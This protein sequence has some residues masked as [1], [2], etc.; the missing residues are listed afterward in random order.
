MKPD[1]SPGFPVFFQ[2]SKLETFEVAPFEVAP[3]MNKIHFSGTKHDQAGAAMEDIPWET[4][5]LARSKV[6]SEKGKPCCQ[7]IVGAFPAATTTP[8][9]K[10][11]LMLVGFFLKK[12]S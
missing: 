10:G 3:F 7:Q 4:E 2:K 12:L 1:F 9:T 5:L 11:Q 8:T 6:R